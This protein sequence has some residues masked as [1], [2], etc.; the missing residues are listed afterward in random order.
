MINSSCTLEW[1]LLVN[2][3]TSY[4]LFA[5]SSTGIAQPPLKMPTDIFQC[6]LW[7]WKTVDKTE[8]TDCEEL[9][10]VVKK[11]Y[12]WLTKKEKKRKQQN[13]TFSKLLASE[14]HSIH[15]LVSV[16]FQSTLNQSSSNHQSASIFLWQVFM[17]TEWKFLWW[18]KSSRMHNAPPPQ[19]RQNRSDF[20]VRVCNSCEQWLETIRWVIPTS[21]KP[22][23]GNIHF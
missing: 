4:G 6:Y 20:E 22:I 14:H 13:A 23:T 5:V 15:H 1:L 19:R 12:L 16:P 2:G 21:D 11:N 8:N 9:R 7:R 18:L 17:P 10:S 3:C